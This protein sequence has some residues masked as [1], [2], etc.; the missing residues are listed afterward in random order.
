MPRLAGKPSPAARAGL[1][2][3]CVIR[4][5]NGRPVSTWRTL[6]DAFRAH[7]GTA[8]S[9]RY[10]DPSG[11][12]KETSFPVPHSLR[13]LLG[14]GPEAR[15][16]R[17]D[18]K[19]TVRMETARG[20]EDVSVGYRRGTRK[21]LEALVGRDVEIVYRPNPLADL[22]SKTIHVTED[23][24]D[25]WVSRISFSPSIE[26]MP[27]MKLLKGAN[28]FD[29]VAI[30]VHKTLYIIRNVYTMME[31]MIF[32]RSVELK[33]I[34]GPL[35]IIDLG[36]RVAKSGPIDFL[37]FLAVISANLAVINFLPLPIVDGGLMVFLLIEKIKGSPVSL[38]VQAATQII[39]IFLIVGVFLLV[40]FND[41]MRL[42]G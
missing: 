20:M 26:L 4:A 40:T 12:V 24:L 15:I 8:V 19:E 23:M 29:A 32:S 39:G 3:G 42:W 1:T 35:G 31:R 14:V 37:F 16:V 13:T 5:V 30:G 28:V 6:I 7:A 36:G 41:A 27:E 38:K 10:E 25:P 21:A 18:G 33:N 22:R 11:A 2:R 9:L 17:I 34:S